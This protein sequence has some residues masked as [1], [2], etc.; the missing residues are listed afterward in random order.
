MNNF[1]KINNSNNSSPEQT[2]CMLLHPSH[3][4]HS[5]TFAQ[6]FGHQYCPRHRF[7]T[8][9]TRATEPRDHHG[10]HKRRQCTTVW[11]GRGDGTQNGTL[12]TTTHLGTFTPSTLDTSTAT[13]HSNTLPRQSAAPLTSTHN[14]HTRTTH[15]QHPWW[16]QHEQQ[17]PVGCLHQSDCRDASIVFARSA[18]VVHS[19]GRSSLQPVWGV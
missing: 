15:P 9:S 7:C 4:R 14:I 5:G 10:L 13:Q 16:L 1:V 18:A 19:W 3:D 2:T 6:Q 17:C 12:D 8:G 11:V